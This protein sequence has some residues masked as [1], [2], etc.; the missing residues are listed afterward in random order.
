MELAEPAGPWG[1]EQ[2]VCGKWG[3]RARG[4]NSPESLRNGDAPSGVGGTQME[5]KA[6]NVMRAMASRGRALS[7]GDSFRFV[8]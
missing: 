7:R 8:V 3:A 1:G 5:N 4:Q 6:P 2:C